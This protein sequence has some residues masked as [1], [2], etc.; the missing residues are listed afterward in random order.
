M[1]PI[2]AI[3][4]EYVLLTVE[5]VIVDIALMFYVLPS[6]APRLPHLFNLRDF[7]TLPLFYT[8]LLDSRLRTS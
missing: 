6:T 2:E 8:C 4:G 3:L 1:Y 7:C 5:L